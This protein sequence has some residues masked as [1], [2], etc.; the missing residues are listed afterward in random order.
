MFEFDYS[1]PQ[2]RQAEKDA[3]A[4]YVKQQLEANLRTLQKHSEIA[5]IDLPPA[6]DLESAVAT[7]TNLL[8]AAGYAVCYK[9]YSREMVVHESY[10][11]LA[12]S[13]YRFVDGQFV[14]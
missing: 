1:T 10:A 7:A 6:A 13:A 11:K 2:S 3:S 4:A 12:A 9:E 14:K 5:G 8:K